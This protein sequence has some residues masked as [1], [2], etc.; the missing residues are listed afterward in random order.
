MKI[1]KS[2]FDICFSLIDASKP[3][4]RLRD[5]CLQCEPET[6]SSPSLL[7]ITP[8]HIKEILP[9][10]SISHHYRY[11]YGCLSACLMR[12]HHVI[13]R[14]VADWPSPQYLEGPTKAATETQPAP[15]Q[16]I[17]SPE[18]FNSDR[19]RQAIRF[20]QTQIFSPLRY[21]KYSPFSICIVALFKTY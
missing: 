10:T 7:R 4:E 17:F 9:Q 1:P 14:S 6:F 8:S 2:F 11:H 3:V 13:F 15:T 20:S 19:V 16:L 12:G 21:P 18:K 5:G